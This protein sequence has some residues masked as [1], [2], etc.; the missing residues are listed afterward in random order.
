MQHKIATKK[1][2]RDKEG[3]GKIGESGE[4]ARTSSDK[5]SVLGVERTARWL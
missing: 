1:Q 4:K 2:Y 3:I 5:V